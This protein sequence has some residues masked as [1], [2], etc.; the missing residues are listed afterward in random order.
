[1]RFLHFQTDINTTYLD[2]NIMQSLGPMIKH[3]LILVFPK[4][5][6]VSTYITRVQTVANQ[7][8]CNGETLMDAKVMDKIFWSLTDDFENV[9][10]VI[11]ESRNMEE[12][13]ID[14]LAGSLEAHEQ[15]KK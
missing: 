15:R 14:D 7:L 4:C 5:L 2:V 3:D 9:V 10:C 12:M 6:H 1:M 8:K 13:T 11:E